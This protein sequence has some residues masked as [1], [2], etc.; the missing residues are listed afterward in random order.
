MLLNQLV[1]INEKGIVANAVNFSL[2][3][4]S[5]KNQH[6]CE[7][8]IFNY[9]HQKS[10]IST[11]GILDIIRRSYHSRTEPN[12]HLMIQQYGKGK[13]HFAVALANFFKQPFDSPEVQGILAQIENAT[14]GK[15]ESVAQGLRIYK[16]DQTHNHLVI[17]CN[18]SG[19]V[20]VW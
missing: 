9:N 5:E 10:H 12:I 8:F 1:E 4:D 2:M 6:L 17:C 11:V 3:E 7:G 16:S 20:E 18:R 15:S 13:S 14:K 19:G